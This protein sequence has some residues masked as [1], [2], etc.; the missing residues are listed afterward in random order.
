[1]MPGSTKSIP[2]PPKRMRDKVEQLMARGEAPSVI[3]LSEAQLKRR[4]KSDSYL[5]GCMTDTS[6]KM[7][8]VYV[9]SGLSPEL[10]HMARVHEIAHCS[11]GWRHR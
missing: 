11:F 4:C 8:L 6:C 3:L 10:E 7:G 5:L 1:M 9:R 2:M